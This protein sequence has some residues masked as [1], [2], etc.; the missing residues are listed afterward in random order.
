[1][2]AQV[3]C[4]RRPA[5]ARLARSE[6]NSRMAQLELRWRHKAHLIDDGSN[7]FPPLTASKRSQLS[8]QAQVNACNFVASS[9]SPEVG[10]LHARARASCCERAFGRPRESA[11]G[12]PAGRHLGRL[13]DRIRSPA[14]LGKTCLL[15]DTS[16]PL[17]SAPRQACRSTHLKVV[18]L[19][20]FCLI[21][22]RESQAKLAS[23]LSAY[24]RPD[25]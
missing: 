2:P 13:P 10:R 4:S 19:I 7:N 6:S 18:H 16:T 22:A 5:R 9:G 1:M 3:N 12:R 23:S 14:G 21:I 20:S 24:H 17:D 8:A 15:S 25:R 11:G